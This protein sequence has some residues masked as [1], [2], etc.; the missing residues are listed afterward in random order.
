M[1]AVLVQLIV[2]E[3]S[4][5]SAPIFGALFFDF[6]FV[7]FCKKKRLICLLFRQ[8]IRNIV[9]LQLLTSLKLNLLRSTTL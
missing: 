4:D 5:K 2:A 8:L 7:N 1:A 6:G 9:N 3:N